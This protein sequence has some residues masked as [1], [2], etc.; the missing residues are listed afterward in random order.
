[1][2]R[3]TF[4]RPQ[5]RNGCSLT[6]IWFGL[7]PFRSPL[8]RKSLRFPFLQVLRCFSS[9]RWPSCPMYSGMSDRASPLP[10]FPIRKSSDR[11]SLSSSPRLI[12]ASRALHRL[13]APRHPP[14]TL[15]NLTTQS[16]QISKESG[17]S[18][19]FLRALS[20]NEGG[21]CTI[22]PP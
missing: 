13:L 2:R 14:C 19:Q 20:R 17:W 18:E 22:E 16:L 11:S 15:H 21:S 12:A 3:Q 4:P 9:L 6:R 7:F 5:T 1:M 10:G 8:L